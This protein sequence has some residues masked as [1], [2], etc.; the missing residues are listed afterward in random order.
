MAP[1]SPSN[2]A[3]STTQGKPVKRRFLCSPSKGFF[4]GEVVA[5]WERGE[6]RSCRTVARGRPG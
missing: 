1:F 4:P 6:G 5:E 3:N 2:L